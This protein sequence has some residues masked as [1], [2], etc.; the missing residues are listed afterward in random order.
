[1]A[2]TLITTDRSALI[3]LA[4][5][6]PKGSPE[7]RAILRLA[8]PP[9]A[10]MRIAY[11]ATT[12]L[13]DAVGNATELT[14][15]LN[16]M[17]IAAEDTFSDAHRAWVSAGNHPDDFTDTPEGRHL[18]AEMQLAEVLAKAVESFGQ[19]ARRELDFAKDAIKKAERFR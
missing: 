18:E 10:V 12:L 11:E 1:M 4:S 3:E 5:S 17:H 2:R 14:R 7:R 13:A 19:K 9:S 6:L 16:A 15:R 8:S